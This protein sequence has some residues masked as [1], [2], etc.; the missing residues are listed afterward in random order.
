[1]KTINALVATAIF[2]MMMSSILVMPVH[3]QV[4]FDSWVGHWFSGNVLDRGVLVDDT[5]T[6][7]IADS[8]NAYGYIQCW[9]EN[10]SMFYIWLVEYDADTGTYRD[11]VPYNLQVINGTPLDFVGYGFL[12]PGTIPEVEILTVIMSFKGYERNGDLI[13]A[14][15]MSVGGCVIYNLGGGMYFSASESIRARMFP[16]SRVPD[17]V[18]EK[19]LGL[20]PC[21]QP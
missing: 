12:P 10:Q 20:P 11:A 8:T 6:A 1:M 16:A 3:A 7:R 13:A 19:L 4:D 18:Q 5:G 2:T 21:P 15:I 9:D 14:Q 17:E